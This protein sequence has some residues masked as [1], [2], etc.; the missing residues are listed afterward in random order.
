[1]M[2]LAVKHGG[3]ACVSRTP[4]FEYWDEKPSNTKIESMAQ[5]LE[6]VSQNN[7]ELLKDVH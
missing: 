1:M 3:E 5:Y 6:D 2:E 4:S 7:E